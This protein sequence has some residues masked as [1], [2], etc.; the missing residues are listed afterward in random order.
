M[1]ICTYYLQFS[2]SFFIFHFIFIYFHIDIVYE[3]IVLR[4]IVENKLTYLLTYLHNYG[5]LI[6]TMAPCRMS[7]L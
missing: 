4:C 2:G 1:W 7:Y 6:S 3:C 5:N